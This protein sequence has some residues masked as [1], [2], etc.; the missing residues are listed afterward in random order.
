MPSV[1]FVRAA[2]ADDLADLTAMEAACFSDPWSE[3]AIA[4]HLASEAAITEIARTVD[5]EAIGYIFGLALGPESEILRVAVLPEHRIVGVGYSLVDS[6][7]FRA[8][9][10]GA[11]KCFLEV[12]E[13]NIAAQ[14]LYE[15]VCFRVKGK[16][17][18]YYKNPTE[19]ALIMVLD[20]I[21]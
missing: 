4:S 7:L 8:I 16:R 13:S 20:P 15:S 17:K 2:T 18:K 19:D 14:C 21:V 1:Y 5:G 10:R 12:R 11:K 3:A 9:N 6:M